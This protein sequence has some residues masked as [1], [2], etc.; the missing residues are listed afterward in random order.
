[1]SCRVLEGIDVDPEH[2]ALEIIDS[3]GPGGNFMTS[4][5]T[6]EHMRDEYCNGNGVADR[7]SSKKWEK[8]GFLDNWVRDRKRT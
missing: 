7:K 3:V 4:P 1:M 2:L 5:H 8:E 6:L